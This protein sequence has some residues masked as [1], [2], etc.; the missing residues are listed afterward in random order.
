MEGNTERQS[1]AKTE[2]TN[3]YN[4]S[5]NRLV[6]RTKYMKAVCKERFDLVAIAVACCALPLEDWEAGVPQVAHKHLAAR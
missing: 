6:A 1:T 2:Q 3:E 4:L 5:A